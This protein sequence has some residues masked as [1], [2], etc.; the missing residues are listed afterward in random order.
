MEPLAVIGLVG[1][2]V[3]FVDFSGRLV[4]KSAE[5][6]RSSEGT[7]AEN[8]NIEAATEHL[9]LLN[10]KLKDGAI[11]TGDGALE[12]LCKLCSA[13]A[14]ELLGALDKIKVKG[15]QQKLGSIRKALRSI[16]SK[17][18]IGELEQRLARFREELKLHVIVD[19]RCV[20]V[21]MGIGNANSLYATGSSS[22]NSSGNRLV[23]LKVSI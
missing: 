22:L 1:N 12:N 13:V 8:I 6:Y 16:W 9:V 14:D 23:A 5:I 17:E 2:I 4:S 3:Q 7:L 21:S 19:L 15:Q 18:K 20:P 10:R 11:I